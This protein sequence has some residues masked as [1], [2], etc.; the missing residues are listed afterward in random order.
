MNQAYDLKFRKVGQDV[1]VWEKAQILFPECITIGNSVIVD[2]FV[3]MSGK[4]SITIG[5]FVH[6][7]AHSTISGGN[8]FIMEDFSALSGGVKIYNSNEDYSGE[9]LTNPTVPEPY[10]IPIRGDIH[11]KKHVVICANAVIL[12]GVTIGEGTVIGAG[13]VITNDV[14]DWVIVNGNPS[15]FTATRRKDKILELEAQLRKKLYD[16][17]RNYISKEHR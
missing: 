12:P 8:R 3:F 1:S 10:R 15:R 17:Q 4:K 14:P 5:D 11:I 9:H 2:D 6:I 16:K 7:A 13:C